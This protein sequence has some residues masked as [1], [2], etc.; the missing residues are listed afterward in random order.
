MRSLII[1]LYLCIS[2]INIGF[3]QK[4]GFDQEHQTK[5]DSLFDVGDLKGAILEFKNS[6]TEDPQNAKIA[7]SLASAFALDKQI[8]SAFHYLFIS[9][10]KDSTTDCLTDA[11]FYFLMQDKRWTKVEDRQ[12]KKIKF[13][14]KYPEVSKE[15]W[16]MIIKDQAFYRHV[17][18]TEDLIGTGSPIAKGL[19]ELKHILNIKNQNRLEEIIAKYGWPKI[20]EF[21]R[22]AAGSAFLIVQHADPALR[23]KYLPMI[24]EAANNGEAKWS[25]LALLIDR[26]N[27]D[28]GKLQIYGSQISKKDDGT[29]DTDDLFEPE[30]V[31]QRRKKVGLMPIEQYVSFWGLEWTIEQKEK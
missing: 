25:S 20:S 9:T 23:Q 3:G 6:F 10:E 7:Y 30:Y 26:S 15:L 13:Q 16:R 2:I 19:W 22:R 28:E 14:Y 12:M 8:D 18:L 1:V 17:F 27:L 11:D 21:G 29:L 4:F 5:G 31:N 24:T